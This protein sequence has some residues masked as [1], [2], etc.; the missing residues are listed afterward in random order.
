MTILR[1]S[2]FKSFG[3]VDFK[4]VQTTKSFLSGIERLISGLK[5]GYK[6][7]LMCSEKNPIECH[8]F[9]L[10]SEYLSKNGFDVS[11][12]TP[13]GEISQSNLELEL[14]EKYKLGG[15]FANSEDYL[16]K[17]YLLLNKEQ[18]IH[19]IRHPVIS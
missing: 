18:R 17:A 3:K 5:K 14:M 8:R 11:H 7:S 15:L 12:I 13:N 1:P 6:I 9:G 2:K 16:N 10:V 4:K 19:L